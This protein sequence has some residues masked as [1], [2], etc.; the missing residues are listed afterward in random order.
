MKTM[1]LEVA[2]NLS[3]AS[4]DGRKPLTTGQ[5]N[6]LK[7][8]TDKITKGEVITKQDIVRCYFDTI[9]INGKVFRERY[10]YEGSYREGTSKRV[11][12]DQEFTVHDWVIQT[13][14]MTWFKLNLGICI[15]KGKLLAI[16]VIEI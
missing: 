15:L 8:L 12:F 5:K 2:P 3:P 16:P 9:A 10:R 6:L 4:F 14:A 1:E 7:L 11:Y 13:G